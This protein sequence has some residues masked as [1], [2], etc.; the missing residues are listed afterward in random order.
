MPHYAKSHR[1]SLIV[2]PSCFLLEHLSNYFFILAE[3]SKRSCLFG[4]DAGPTVSAALFSFP[5][6]VPE[7]PNNSDLQSLS[8]CEVFN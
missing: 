3:L 6:G 8:R 7:G 5:Y 2:F 1:I 4:E